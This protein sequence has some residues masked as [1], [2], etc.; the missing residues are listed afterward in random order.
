MGDLNRDGVL[1][2]YLTD[3][4]GSAIRYTLGQWGLVT[5]NEDIDYGEILVVADLNGDGQSDC[6][7][8]NADGGATLYLYTPATE[9]EGATAHE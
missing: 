3:N 7:Q 8:Q 2:L 9:E 1:E 5:R 6:I 4:Y